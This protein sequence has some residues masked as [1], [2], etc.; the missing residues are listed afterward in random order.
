M[1]KNY[2]ISTLRNLYKR[3][4]YSLINIFGLAIGMACFLLIY[5]YISDELSYDKHHKNADNIYRLVN[6]YDF[7]GVG[8]NSASAPF[9]VAFTLQNDFPEVIRNVVRLFNFQ[10]PRS[11]V[12][13]EEKKFN[14]KRFFF[15][16]STYFSIFDHHFIQGNPKNAL[17]KIGSLVITQ[18]MAK[19]YF[20]NEDPI[21]KSVKFEGGLSL[22]VTA[23]IEDVPEESHF[24]F[25]FMGSMSSLRNM[26]GGQLPKTWVWNPCWTYL[27]L[28]ENTDPNI[29][30][31]KFPEFVQKYFYDA[32]KDNV[33]MYLQ[34]LTDIHLKS[35]LDYELAP[36][37]DLTSIY[38]LS[39]IAIF[40]LIIAVINYMNLA[41][42]T[43]AG[44]S[45]EIGI[46]KVAGAN[47]QQL[48]IQFIGES[49]ILT[50]IALLISLLII[51]IVMPVFNNFTGKN[52][53][54]TDLLT[55]ENMAMMLG[56]GVFIGFISG[57]YPAFYLSTFSPVQV[58]KSQIKQGTKSG[59]ARK[60]LVITQF[61]I[62]ITLI[63]G[64]LIIG[65]Q[66]D[67]MRNADLGFEKD[68]IIVL[69]INNTPVA[70]TYE[71]FKKE[72]LQNPNILSVTIMDDIFG[73]AH[74]THEFRPEGYP[75]D[76][77]QFYPALVVQYDF[78]K[79]FG[80]KIIAGRDYN[81]ANRTDP[82]KGILI[83][84]AMV[85]HMGWEN[86]QAALGKKFRSL[87]GEERV[88]GVFNDFHQTSLHEAAG[89][90]V[91]NMKETPGAIRFFMKYM[92]IKISEGSDQTALSLIEDKWREVAPDRPFE[93]FYLEDELAELY[94]DEE[95]L[96]KLSVLFTLIIMFIAALG[97]VGLASYMAEQKTK[98]IGVRRVLGA[99]T[100]SIIKR[101]SMEFV[102]LILIASVLAWVLAYIIMADW[103]NHFPY[104]TTLN[105]VIF[106][107]ATL[108]SLL[109]ALVISGIRGWIAAQADPVET[110]KYE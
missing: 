38:V 56:L 53:G 26:F 12:E 28:G 57:V 32:E 14:E 13:Y 88:I 105:W 44:R 106:V 8:E 6:I 40:L 20:A 46:K 49:I 70:R 96:S 43:S 3:K 39:A 71:S 29:L 89:P 87:Q 10:A 65:D 23:V 85:N 55:I 4:T 103:L 16:D 75:E 95:N 36:N 52:I 93:Y 17:D 92:A 81:E 99:T 2:L 41:T 74:N 67:F 98:E 19:K 73:A 33:S 91:L 84:E 80:I 35:K 68:N 59:M 27:L 42:A 34:P 37:N 69:P 108:V 66:L 5:L 9:P 100:L 72:L 64:T 77:W 76:Q 110:L 21:G 45:K 25:D 102:W 18:S 82:E 48:I 94:K 15:A 101:L 54:F 107:L 62:S 7:E 109:I 31:E 86:P 60:A 63:I 11:F 97:L 24:K 50:L 30:E 61:A 104:Q 22:V 83:N 51:E 58:L 90:F 47:K 1:F 79:T 78:L